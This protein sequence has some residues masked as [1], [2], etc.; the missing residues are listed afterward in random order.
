MRLN[1]GKPFPTRLAVA[2]TPPPIIRQE[3]C[4]WPPVVPADQGELVAAVRRTGKRKRRRG[5]R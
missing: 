4:Q 5:K 2:S 3:P 1:D